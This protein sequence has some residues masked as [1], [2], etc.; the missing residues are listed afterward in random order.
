MTK[1]NELIEKYNIDRIERDRA[2]GFAYAIINHKKKR[3]ENYQR[4]IGHILHEHFF[5]DIVYSHQFDP[6]E[7]PDLQDH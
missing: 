1:A 7:L 4:R 2:A 5:V 6:G 3:L